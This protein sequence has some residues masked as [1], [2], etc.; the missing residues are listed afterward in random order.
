MQVLFRA[1]SEQLVSLL[2]FSEHLE[3]FITQSEQAE[4]AI[5]HLKL[6]GF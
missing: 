5:K 6:A 3:W 1:I 4:V 2:F